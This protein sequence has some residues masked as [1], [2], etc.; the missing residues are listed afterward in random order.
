VTAKDQTKWTF[1]T[2]GRLRTIA[3]RYQN[4]ST[5]DYDGQN[6]LISISDPAGRGLLSLTNNPTNGR[7]E[8]LTDWASRVVLFRYDAVNRLSSVVDRHNFAAA[9]P[10]PATTYGY[11]GTVAG[12]A[13]TRLTDVYNP[14]G[15]HLLQ[16]HYDAQGRVDWQRDGQGILTGQLTSYSYQADGALVTLPANTWDAVGR[17]SSFQPTIEDHYN[18]SAGWVTSRVSR[19]SNEAEAFTVSYGYDS[20]GNRTSVTDAN[21]QTTTSCFDTANTNVLARG[22]LLAKI[23]PRPRP[24]EAQLVT[25]Y[26]YDGANNLLRQDPPRGVNN[27]AAQTIT[28][29]GGGGTT[30][31]TAL[32]GDPK[33][34]TLYRY[35]PNATSPTQIEVE[36]KYTNPGIPPATP[37]VVTAITTRFYNGLGQLTSETPPRG[38]G[39]PASNVYATVHEYYPDDDPNKRGGMR[40]GIKAPLT[41]EVYFDYDRVGRL[42]EKTDEN[43]QHWTYEYD[44]ED[45]TRFS[46]TP[47]VSANGA[48]PTPLVTEQRYNAAGNRTLLID[49]R[50][51]VTRYDYDERELL[52]E[53]RQ[54][55]SRTDPDLPTPDAN[56]VRT[57]YEYDAL[58]NRQWVKRYKGNPGESVDGTQYLYDGAGRLR[59]ERQS[60][61]WPTTG[62]CPGANHA[63]PDCLVTTYAYDN[64]GNRIWKQ[65]PQRYID[66]NGGLSASINY[67]YDALNR[68]TAVLYD[69]TQNTPNEAY[70]YDRNGNRESMTDG[71]GATGTATTI[72]VYDERD[73]LTCVAFEGGDCETSVGRI[74]RY[75]YDV[76]GRRVKLVYPHGDVVTYTY[77]TAGRL[78][79]LS[80][81]VVGLSNPLQ[82]TY[83]YQAADGKLQK[84]EHFNGTRQTRG[85][86]AAGRLTAVTN[87][88]SSGI[89]VQDL[90]SKL[91]GLGN[92]TEV[93]ATTVPGYPSGTPLAPVLSFTYDGLNRL[94]R[95]SGDPIF[96][97]LDYTYDTAS[98]RA[99]LTEN[100]ALRPAYGYDRAE[101]LRSGPQ[102][103]YNV[104]ANGRT[105]ARPLGGVQQPL[106]FNQA[107]RLTEA[108]AATS[109]VSFRYDGDGRRAVRTFTDTTTNPWTTTTAVYTDDVAGELPVMLQ[110][111]ERRY[112]YG[113]GLAY[114]LKLSDPQDGQVYHTDARG[115]VRA[116]TGRTGALRWVVRYDPFGTSGVYGEGGHPPVGFGG[117]PVEAETGLVYMRARYYDPALG[118]FLSRDSVAGSASNP[119]SLN[120]YAYSGSNPVSNVDPSGHWFVRVVGLPLQPNPWNQLAAQAWAQRQAATNPN[121]IIT[122]LSVII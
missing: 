80:D 31:Y 36:R 121:A 35:T 32:T 17:G 94:T 107:D 76:D 65:K 96:G 20:S 81:A 122:E 63:D 27:T 120:R 98:N 28:C 66:Q 104:D 82:T 101:R 109:R 105:T 26:R 39:L 71:S 22:N 115:S 67:T 59:Q 53:V 92:P 103:T 34:A 102:G 97:T 5:L 58:G 3:D 61:H 83:T 60:P 6:R 74:V 30:A 12:Q 10:K 95:Y 25:L 89:I 112:V 54:S 55:P 38:Y 118:R 37:T 13:T 41:N 46:R 24:G 70:T 44:N 43:G 11:D 106:I 108:T 93:I 86:D 4:T 87:D 100:G 51:Q 84:I 91:D 64:V 9:E 15:K 7:L 75:R 49:A 69:P 48:T 68:R 72:Y 88:S 56:M 57:R 18:V 85:Y 78:E 73:Q 52:A 90:V 110:D 116:V 14:N 113:V 47:P 45:R 21:N 29:D 8:A 42:V 16:Q 1:D 23:Q 62:P 50:G 77:D 19:P 119:I 111:G 2:C 40:K 117:E 114:S 79:A 33:Y 99:T